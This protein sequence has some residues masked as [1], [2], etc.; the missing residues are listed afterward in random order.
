MSELV[1]RPAGDTDLPVLQRA[2]YHAAMWR[3]EQSD[4]P[5]ERVLAHEYF[6]MYHEGWGRPGD[7][8]V[9]ADV[10]G[11]PVG[12][13]YGRLF[14][15]DRHG[16]GYVHPEI[17]EIAVGVEP[18]HRGRGIGAALL[19]ALA[20]AYRAAGTT[21]LSLSV[22]KDNPA[23]RLY[24]WHGY[25]TLE[26]DDNALVML[27]GLVR[28]AQP[29]YHPR[30]GEV[31]R[32]LARIHPDEAQRSAAR[33]LLARYGGEDWHRELDRVRLA[34][35]RLAGTD[36]AATERRVADASV[37]YRDTLVAAEYPRFSRLPVGT[38]PASEAYR[39]AIEDDAADY[40][41]WVRA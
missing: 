29:A 38:D 3:G 10:A 41:A 40:L 1:V 17:P 25:V 32:V 6:A 12:A 4:Y 21:A 8:G 33:D 11:E 24:R 19:V 16:H 14:S 39:K 23:V 22:E 5:P 15:E 37:D 36:L 35:L 31:E 9:V 34:V 2:L 20:D 26:E 18:A 7:R 13:A 30:P 28:P 27:K